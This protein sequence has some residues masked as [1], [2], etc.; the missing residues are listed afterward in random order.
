MNNVIRIQFRVQILSVHAVY[1]CIFCSLF[2]WKKKKK[3]ASGGSN[4]ML[5]G[6][7]FFSSCPGVITCSTNLSK[8]MFI[9]VLETTLYRDTMDC[10]IV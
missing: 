1:Y 10:K 8:T 2:F 5:N 6:C 3:A 9:H 7:V 4:F